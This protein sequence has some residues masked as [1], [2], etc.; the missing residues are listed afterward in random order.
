M[1]C[2]IRSARRG[3]EAIGSARAHSR[4]R[5]PA[6]A[7][8]S[9]RVREAART[10][11][12]HSR[13]ASGSRTPPFA[14][15][16]QVNLDLAHAREGQRDAGLRE[17]PG[18]FHAQERLQG[19]GG[20]RQER[21][22][23]GRAAAGGQ[24]AAACQGL[25]DVSPAQLPEGVFGA[26]AGDSI[27]VPGAGRQGALPR[28]GRGARGRPGRRS[29]RLALAVPVRWLHCSEEDGR[30]PSR[31][32]TTVAATCASLPLRST[33]GQPGGWGRGSPPVGSPSLPGGGP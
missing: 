1:A 6:R 33:P 15:P 17:P 20:I 2:S 10:R 3:S 8:S 14:D 13:R 32:E 5:S 30:C 27:P 24:P 29:G 7:R 16:S 25:E 23:Q 9:P 26:H 28:P 31:R 19:R 21:Q 4:G 11:A 22:G 18:L 12:A